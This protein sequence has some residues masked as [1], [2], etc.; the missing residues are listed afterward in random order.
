MFDPFGKE[1]TAGT[2]KERKKS[3]KEFLVR[4]LTRSY[5]SLAR[6]LYG[7]IDG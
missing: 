4:F 5:V 6:R 3:V 2:R 7:A 1:I